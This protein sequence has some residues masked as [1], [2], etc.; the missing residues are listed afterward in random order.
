[1]NRQQATK[2]LTI[3]TPSTSAHRTLPFKPPTLSQ[4][5]SNL[6]KPQTPS[7]PKIHVGIV[8][9]V[10]TM[11]KTVHVS[12][13]TQ[14]FDNWLKRHTQHTTRVLAHE[15]TGYL[16]AG[17][18]VEFARFTPLTMAERYECGKLDRRGGGVRYEVHRVITP[19]GERV[20]ERKELKGRGELWENLGSIEFERRKE[21][22]VR[23]WNTNPERR[24]GILEGMYEAVRMEVERMQ[25]ALRSEPSNFAGSEQAP[26]EGE[27]QAAGGGGTIPAE[28]LL[29]DMSD[30]QKDIASELQRLQQESPPA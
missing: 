14:R 1:M 5:R 25:G 19:F 30:A 4:I 9:R 6:P 27:Q 24:M 26:D 23:P 3:P 8:S 15:P 17:D 13:N 20:E 16:R 21:E 18:V 2:H 10:G 7:I 29:D 11:S 28:D 22:L 12:F